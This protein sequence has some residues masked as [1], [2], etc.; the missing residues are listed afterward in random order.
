MHQKEIPLK[1]RLINHFCFYE[2]GNKLITAGVDGVLVFQFDIKR[3]Q[4][5][6]LAVKLDPF[7]KALQIKVR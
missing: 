6:C 1:T 7:G 4:P 5:P 2:E 3:T